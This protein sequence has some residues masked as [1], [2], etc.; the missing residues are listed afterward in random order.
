MHFAFKHSK[1]KATIPDSDNHPDMK[2]EA[3]A[4]AKEAA[5][6]AKDEELSE[7]P[8][9]PELSRIDTSDFPGAFSL[10]MITVALMLSIFLCALGMSDFAIPLSEE[11]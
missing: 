11:N 5:M 2:D 9:E 4:P 7:N 10:A 1:P 8:L 3:A 6:D